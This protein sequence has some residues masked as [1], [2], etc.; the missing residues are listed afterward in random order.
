MLRRHEVYFFAGFFLLYF[1]CGL[2]VHG[3]GFWGSEE[4]YLLERAL[5]VVRG[6]PA[7]F[8]NVGL[9]YPPL[10]FALLF[11]PAALGF[12]LQG[13]VFMSSLCG[14]LTACFLSSLTKE[15]FALCL[16]VLLLT[17]PLFLYAF[18]IS[19]SQGMFLLILVLY[20]CF[21]KRFLEKRQKDLFVFALASLCFGVA[22]VTR[23][24]TLFFLFPLIFTLIRR[25]DRWLL[26]SKMAI[27]IFPVVF[28]FGGWMYINWLYKGDP[29][30]FVHTL[31]MVNLNPPVR[32]QTSW[33]H[34]LMPLLYFPVYLVSLWQFKGR[35]QFLLLLLS[36]LIVAFIVLWFSEV[37]L[38]LS[39][40]ALLGGI[41]FVFLKPPRG[42]LRPVLLL[43]T[44]AG[45][46]LGWMSPE[47]WQ[48]GPE[49]SFVALVVKREKQ[50]VFLQEKQ[51]AAYLKKLNG[52]IFF[53]DTNGYPVV[54]FHGNPKVFILPYQFEFGFYIKCPSLISRYLALPS[55]HGK[56]DAVNGSNSDIFY[57][58]NPKWKLIEQVGEW[59]I[60]ESIP[61]AFPVN[62]P[63]DRIGGQ[64]RQ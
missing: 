62:R 28:L 43:G 6:Q 34:L 35:G 56:S 29:L 1:F 3:M 10:P 9:T 32:G 14:G 26:L 49:R 24:E 55:P 52:R 2:W 46:W 39:F 33:L 40:F 38:S 42:W 19:G 48:W 25:E 57:G 53:D 45:I 58:K 15:K 64:L 37:V 60:F 54:F 41:G 50:E 17:H 8:E 13:G 18:S 47:G 23:Y 51:V 21:H 61:R 63:V 7:R 5:L 4:V 11:I 12:H 59:R 20:V 16:L 44:M 36:P 30:Y 31:S 27:F 22:V